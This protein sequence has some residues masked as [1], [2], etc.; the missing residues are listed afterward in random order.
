MNRVGK[1]RA[2]SGPKKQY[3]EYKEFHQNEVHAH[4]CASFME[5]L[6]MQSIDGNWHTSLMATFIIS[7]GFRV[8]QNE[9]QWGF[10]F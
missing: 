7:D 6:S 3:N 4:I 5:L 2:S 1:T 10:E 9:L 8:R